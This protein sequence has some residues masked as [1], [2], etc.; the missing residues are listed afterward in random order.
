MCCIIFN[1]IVG[2]FPRDAFDMRHFVAEFHTVK[3]GG[4]FQKFRPEGCGN[5]LRPVCQFVY[6][7]GHRFSVRGIQGGIDL[8]EKVKRGR[9]A[10]LDGEDQRQGNE[11]LLTAGQLSHLFHFGIFAFKSKRE[12]KRI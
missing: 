2:I 11:G 4:M 7:V 12:K 5:K 8:V 6:H 10:F 9:I 3:L 1:E